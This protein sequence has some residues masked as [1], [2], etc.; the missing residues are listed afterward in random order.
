MSGWV[1]ENVETVM[2]FHVKRRIFC[3]TQT[4]NL[5]L[6]KETALSHNLVPKSSTLEGVEVVTISK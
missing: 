2:D 4:M 5:D 3:L 1:F 6:L